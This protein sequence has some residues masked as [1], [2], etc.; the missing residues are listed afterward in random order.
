[1]LFDIVS[2]FLICRPAL[3][4][5]CVDAIGSKEPSD[6]LDPEG[7]AVQ[8]LRKVMCKALGT[9]LDEDIA[10]LRKGPAIRAQSCASLCG[11]RGQKQLEIQTMK[12]LNGCAVE[13][14]RESNA[15]LG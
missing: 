7:E 11:M 14:R 1:M 13:P 9:D 4:Q 12:Y 2:H 10:E 3:E 15:I 8:D 5:A 6:L